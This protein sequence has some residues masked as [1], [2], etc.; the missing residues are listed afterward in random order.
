[1][2]LRQVET[3]SI[4]KLEILSNQ[5][6]KKISLL[7]GTEAPGPR[8]ST[9]LYYE[10][11]RQDTV[12]AEVIFDDTGGAVDD[13]STIEGLPLIGTEQ[14][15]LTFEDN[16]ENKIKL[17]LYVNKVTPITQDTRKIRVK[18]DLVSEEYILNEETRLNTRF[19]G[20]ISDHVTKILKSLKTKKKL[21]IESSSNNFN[22]IG[23]NRKPY[24][25][26]N[27]L[28][29]SAISEKD[30]QKGSSAGFF[31]FE[32]SD[33]FKFK[34]I[35][36]LFAQEKKKSF[37]YNETMGEVPSGYD[38]KILSQQIDNNINV[39]QKFQMGAYST[40]LVVFDPF[41]CVYEVINQSADDTK[42][43]ARLAG[44]DLPK[45][46][47]KFKSD[48]TRTTYMLTDKGTLPTGNS[49]QQVSK[50]TE[51]NFE[52]QQILNQ[53]IRRYNQIFSAVQTITIPGDFSLHAGDA[54]FVDSPELNPQKDDKIN[55]EYGGLYI[56]ADL[57]HYISQKETYTKLN[58]VRDSFGRKGNHTTN[59][60]P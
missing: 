3:S 29:R 41:N 56:I 17:Q 13:K 28:S 24:Y 1:M 18:L 16:K 5:G 49:Q 47:S 57:C 19:D 40:R 54:I 11:I 34:S 21:D 22:F 44:K 4:S 48:F 43:G 2:A 33:G 25:T 46:N 23:N 8:L 26:L 51:Q 55:R 53:S 12:K 20:R 59:I 37:I 58:L 9:L 38:G 7:G 39:Q 42:S 45:F 60:Q 32:T 6:G 27:W 52:T 31:F 30:A 35:D 14:V 15:N 50:S 36:G 10:S